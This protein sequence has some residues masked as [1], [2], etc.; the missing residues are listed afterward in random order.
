MKTLISTFAVLTFTTLIA[1]TVSAQNYS[2]YQRR[3]TQYRPNYGQPVRPP[4]VN[5]HQIRQQQLRQ[6]QHHHAAMLNAQR[7]QQQINAQRQQAQ[8]AYRNRPINIHSSGRSVP[9][10]RKIG[11]VA[12]SITGVDING[13]H[14]QVKKSWDNFRDS[15]G[16]IPTPKVFKSIAKTFGW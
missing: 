6:Q 2:Q 10:W 12:G 9:D 14:R 5:Y 8:M 7:R 11:N 13:K 4:N 16:G 1:S 15:V 3:H